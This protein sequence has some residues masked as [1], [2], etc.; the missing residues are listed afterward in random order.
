MDIFPHDE[1]ELDLLVLSRKTGESIIIGDDVVVKIL[2]FNGSQVKIGI[3]CPDE[4]VILRGELKR[5]EPDGCEDGLRNGG[6]RR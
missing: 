1:K 6:N 4:V 2:G 5:D 3:A